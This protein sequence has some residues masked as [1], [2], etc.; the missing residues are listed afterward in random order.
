LS[1]TNPN[2]LNR[3]HPRFPRGLLF[4]RACS[5]LLA[6]S[7]FLRLHLSPSSAASMYRAALRSSPRALRAIRP[8]TNLAASPRR[9]LTT[10]PAPQRRTWKGFAARWGLA[11]AAVYWYNTSP[12]FA[13]EP[14]CECLRIHPL[15]PPTK[16]VLFWSL[17]WSHASPNDTSTSAVLRLGPTYCRSSNRTKTKRETSSCGDP[18]RAVLHRAADRYRLL[19]V[20]T[21]CRCLTSS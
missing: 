11:L 14:V 4:P 7:P 20:T 15:H 16:P 1:I 3:R 19:G 6:G 10:A 8:T 13:D 2:P 17:T 9:H 18:C 12:I 21:D 5:A